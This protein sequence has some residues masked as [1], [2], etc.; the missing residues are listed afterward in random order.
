MAIKSTKNQR[1]GLGAAGS[2]RG[3][4]DWLVAVIV[5]GIEEVIRVKELQ[6]N[7]IDEEVG[8]NRKCYRQKN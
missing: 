2:Y 1:E 5:K 3:G 8:D 4:W 6:G 7:L